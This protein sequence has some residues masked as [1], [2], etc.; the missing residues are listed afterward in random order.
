MWRQAVIYQ[1]YPWTFYEDPKRKPQRGIGSLKGITQKLPYLREELGVDAI[2]LSP[3]YKS[4]MKDCGYD[5]S[6]YVDIHPDL[7]DMD[8]FDKLIEKAHDLG[9][10]IMIDFVANHT[11]DQ[12]EWFQKSRKRQDGFDDWYIWHPGKKDEHGNRIPP[13]NWASV[14]SMPNK[15]ARERGEFA[16]LRPDEWT[17]PI[18][19]WQWDEERGEYYLHSFAKEQPDLNWSN[20]V[21]RQAMKDVMRFWLDKGVD[22]FRVDAINWMGKNMS[23]EDEQVNTA[24]SEEYYG[25]PYDQLLK[26]NSCNYMNALHQYIWEMCEVLR[27]EQYENRDLRMILEAHMGESELRELNAIAP[28]V[29]STFNFGAMK[30]KWSAPERRLQLDY[31][32]ENLDARNIGNQVN[33]NH[34]ETRLASRLGDEVARTA[35]VMNFFLPGMKFIYNGEELGLHNADVPLEKMRDHENGFRD[36]ERT[37]MI[38]D[39]RQENAGF[40]SADADQ[41]WLPINTNDLG[42][43]LARQ[44]NDPKSS[45]SLYRAA[46]KLAKEIEAFRSGAYRSVP[47]N[48]IDVFA[49]ERK[50]GDDEALV[51][52]NFS[53]NMQYVSVAAKF[54]QGKSVLSSVDVTLNPQEVNLTEGLHLQPNEAMVVLPV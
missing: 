11:S 36:G 19:A 44:E 17:P 4:P 20:P 32:Y 27:E 18:S 24:Y 26:A 23:L 53:P 38:W 25:N 54:S 9:L 28:D 12:H 41:L 14:F 39:D 46:I 45:F 37:P 30:L 13:N 40:S 51:L 6:S 5:I 42:N 48:N 49:F 15:K 52:V 33:G 10:K 31:Y 2:W 50:S 7:G 1:I 3:F 43:S 21:V 16:E 22:G 8:D 34:D 29:S 47:T 35:A